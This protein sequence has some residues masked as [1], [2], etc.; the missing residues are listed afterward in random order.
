[1][2]SGRTQEDGTACGFGGCRYSRPD[3]RSDTFENISSTIGW[4]HDFDQ[5][6]QSFA[7]ISHAFRAPQATE[8]YR[9]Q[10]DQLVADLKSEKINNLE[11]GYRASY[12]HINYT[13]SAYHMEKENVIFQN[14]DRENISNGQTSHT[15]LE[16]STGLK[17]SEQLSFN[18]SASYGDHRYT[19]DI[20][21]RG[22]TEVI[23]GNQIDTSPKFISN[24]QLGWTISSQQYLALEWI[25]LGK[26]Y[27]D[28]ANLNEYPGH[29]LVN[30]RYQ[31]NM[32]GNWHASARIT[33]LLD[34]D[35][36]ERADY[37]FG[38]ERYFVGEPLSLYVSMGAKF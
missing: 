12:D 28:E 35:Y 9:L 18:L 11:L 22:V 14:S 25:H 15:G 17:L 37:G 26:Y 27:T 7:N 19:Q 31:L 16:L 3:D 10:N 33:N 38:N 34:T 6:S 23:D 21:P 36:A 4:I 8:L 5:N 24:A 29:D 30:L 20:A 13:V 1:M 32:T 2:L